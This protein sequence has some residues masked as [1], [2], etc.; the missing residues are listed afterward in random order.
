M[1]RVFESFFLENDFSILIGDKD[2]AIMMYAEE[3]CCPVI[4]KDTDFLLF[5]NVSVVSL[6]NTGPNARCQIF[7]KG[8]KN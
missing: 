3:L 6:D 8:E 7:E 5:G 2:R 4:S 1:P